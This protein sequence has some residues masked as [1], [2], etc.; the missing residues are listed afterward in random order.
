MLYNSNKTAVLDFYEDKEGRRKLMT[1]Y[2]Y[3][4]LKSE[5]VG[6]AETE[7]FGTFEWDYKGIS[8]HYWRSIKISILII[9]NSAHLDGIAKRR[10]K[11]QN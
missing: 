11:R 10:G 2:L 1:F 6:D 3:L 4:Q 9:Q 7:Q 8:K 5:F